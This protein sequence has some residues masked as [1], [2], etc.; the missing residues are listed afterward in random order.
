MPHAAAAAVE[1]EDNFLPEDEEPA[2]FDDL[3]GWEVPICGMQKLIR[4][5]VV[6]KN[7]KA[8]LLKQ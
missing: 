7:S 5:Q 6:G 1:D 2:N 4:T 3:D 8:W